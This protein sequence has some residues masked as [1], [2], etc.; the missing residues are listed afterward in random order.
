MGNKSN[1]PKPCF[2]CKSP[3]VTNQIELT[4]GHCNVCYKCDKSLEEQFPTKESKTYINGKRCDSCP[5]MLTRVRYY[6]YSAPVCQRCNDHYHSESSRDVSKLIAK[7][8][9]SDRDVTIGYLCVAC[10]FK[11]N[12]L[13]AIE[14][15]TMRYE[16]H[17]CR[18]VL[19]AFWNKAC[20]D[21][22]RQVPYWEFLSRV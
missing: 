5:D 15:E 7:K 10:D 21:D 4:S 16:H 14:L 8:N 3:N 22:G 1:K 6:K 2:C 11:Y 19:L 18:E 12:R 17:S 20:K 13:T 9:T